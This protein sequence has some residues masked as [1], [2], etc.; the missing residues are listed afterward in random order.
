MPVLSFPCWCLCLFVCLY[1]MS[2]LWFYLLLSHSE[3]A[4]LTPSTVAASL[5]PA[6]PPRE[7]HPKRLQNGFLF[8]PLL[9]INQSNRANWN[10]MDK[11]W[12][13]KVGVEKEAM[14]GACMSTTHAQIT[15]RLDLIPNLRY[16]PLLPFD[17]LLLLTTGAL[18]TDMWPKSKHFHWCQAHCQTRRHPNGC[19]LG[20]HLVEVTWPC[21]FVFL[22]S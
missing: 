16:W 3:A 2:C 20:N 8:H 12:Q 22:E 14:L 11:K 9:S 6:C 19:K 10:S 1:V 7:T 18:N 17:L 21:L 13:E 5:P 15:S 4:I